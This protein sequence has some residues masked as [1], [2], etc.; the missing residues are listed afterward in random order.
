MSLAAKPQ[1]PLDTVFNYHLLR[2]ALERFGKNLSQLAP[3]EHQQVQRKAAKSFDLESSVIASE[4]AHGL[5]IPPHRVEQSI[6]Q[7]ASR[8]DSSDAFSRDMAANGLDE[9]GLRRALHRELLFDEVMQ[10]VAARG[11]ELEDI[12]VRLF[13]EMHRE[14]FQ[15]PEKRLLSHILITVNPDFPDNVRATALSRMARLAEKLAG[16]SN[17]FKDFAKRYSECPTA[18]EG[19]RLGELPRGQL[20]PELD[21]TSFGME[22]DAISPIVETE[23]GFHLLWCEKI[24]RAKTLSFSKAEPRIRAMLEDRR[25]RNR[26]KA[27]LAGLSK[28]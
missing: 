26:Q 16:R 12:D 22:E 5:M 18:M 23:M 20:Y 27:W 11:A 24:K 2:H 14:R 19:G 13:Y 7:V 17:R 25:R 10:R 21:A 9:A 3:N 15:L 4:E 28:S 6:A 8:Y 1:N